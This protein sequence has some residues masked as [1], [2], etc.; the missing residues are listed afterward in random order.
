MQVMCIQGHEGLLTE[1]DIYTVVYVTDKG[2]F[3]LEE[4]EVPEP[5][6]SFDANRFIPLTRERVLEEEL[7]EVEEN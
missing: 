1:G 5:Y 6:T 3:L 2:N 7:S 4:I